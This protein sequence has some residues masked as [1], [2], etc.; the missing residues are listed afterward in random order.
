MTSTPPSTPQAI[1]LPTDILLNH[2]TRRSRGRPPRRYLPS[3]LSTPLQP[4]V[5]ASIT[6]EYALSEPI[7]PSTQTTTYTENI[8]L[9]ENI[10]DDNYDWYKELFDDQGHYLVGQL[11][12]N[13]HIH[14]SS[15]RTEEEYYTHSTD[16]TPGLLVTTNDFLN[17]LKNKFEPGDGYET[18]TKSIDN[19]PQFFDT[20]KHDYKIKRHSIGACAHV[21]WLDPPGLIPSDIRS[22]RFKIDVRSTYGGSRH[23]DRVIWRS[24][25][26]CN[27]SCCVVDSNPEE[28]LPMSTEEMFIRFAHTA[29][30]Q[31][32]DPPSSPPSSDI[33]NQTS[34][35]KHRCKANLIVEITVEQALHGQCSITMLAQ[36][37][38]RPP[39]HL[40]SLNVSPR[41]RS[42]LHEAAL[43]LGMTETRLQS[44][45]NTLPL[46][47]DT[48]TK[49]VTRYVPHRLPLSKEFRTAIQVALRRDR[50]DK[51]PLA[52][53]QIIAD[54]KPQE[55]L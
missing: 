1:D 32:N 5:S 45:F 26:I 46:K 8:R 44:W 35:G 19:L 47:T 49:W 16:T 39:Q 10:K 7:R 53:I 33:T 50:L 42:Y 14:T 29:V 43:N 6:C 27:G 9:E 41:I 55:L 2:V 54:R 40:L 34:T 13:A 15:T 24:I 48:Y 17:P 31:K 30:E 21:R 38:H 36:D 20:L 12:S 3:P 22:R 11:A 28:T 23:Q 18:V 25:F 51:E 52:A 37:V 4:D